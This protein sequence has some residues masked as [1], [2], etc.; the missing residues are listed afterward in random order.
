MERRRCACASS[1]LFCY[2]EWV[3]VEEATNNEMTVEE[4]TDRREEKCFTD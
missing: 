4:T 2:Y 1:T 3:R